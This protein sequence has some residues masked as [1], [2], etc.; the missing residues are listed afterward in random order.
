L[1]DTNATPEEIKQEFGEQ[2]LSVVQE[3]SDDKSLGKAERKR[4]QVEHSPHISK[5]AK[6]V[7]LADKL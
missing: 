3:V 7:K 5:E 4:H 2:V 1:E 6:T